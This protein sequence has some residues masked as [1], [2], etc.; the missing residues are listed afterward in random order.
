[1]ELFCIVVIPNA[2]YSIVM[3]RKRAEFKVLL[4]LLLRMKLKERIIKEKLILFIYI[5]RVWLKHF[6]RFTF[7]L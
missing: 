4:G 2:R 5:D 3:L 7:I 6:K 1:M